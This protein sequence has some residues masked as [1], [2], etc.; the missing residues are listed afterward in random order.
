[1]WLKQSSP[2]GSRVIRE[3]DI[4]RHLVARCKAHGVACW[5]WVS[6]NNRAVPDRLLLHNGEWWAIELKAPG[7][8]P[9]KLQ[10][11]V[12]N[13]IT[14]HGGRVMVLDSKEK[15]DELIQWIAG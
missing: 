13:E 10:Q 5:K 4:E 1:M 15:V 2:S 8:K 7:R 12:M 3:R 11:V 14:R 9:T 6:P